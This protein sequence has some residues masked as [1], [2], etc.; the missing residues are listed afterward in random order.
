MANCYG[1]TRTNYFRVADEEKFE[2]I[3]SS[4]VCCEDTLEVWYKTVDGIK[5]YAFG[6]NDSIA[7]ICECSYC[8]SC[9]NCEYKELEN[10]EECNTCDCEGEYNYDKMCELLQTVVHPEDA[11]IIVETAH[12][13]LRYVGASSTVITSKEIKHIDIWQESMEAV[14][15]ML[16]KKEYT[17][18]YTY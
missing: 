4:V 11:I 1:N 15:N 10:N 16:D 9:N 14:K 13:K 8:N 7:G 2:E 18:V 17:P 5:E 12:E 3:I 6:A